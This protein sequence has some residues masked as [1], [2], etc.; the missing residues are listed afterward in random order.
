MEAIGVLVNEKVAHIKL[1]ENFHASKHN[2]M[3]VAEQLAVE[4][5]VRYLI[6]LGFK[7]SSILI[8]VDNQ[9][10]IGAWYKRRF[11]SALTNKFFV[12]LFALTA[13]V[14]LH[15]DLSYINTKLNPVD[16]VSRGDLS[17][18]GNGKTARLLHIDSLREIT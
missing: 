11:R 4:V 14:N 12:R 1:S 7:D 3:C 17:R 13:E 9:G 15:M 10:V 6:A 2:D 8:H 18:T 16:A 5:V